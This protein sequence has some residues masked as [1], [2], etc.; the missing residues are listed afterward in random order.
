MSS[1]GVPSGLYYLST[2]LSCII[3]L[4][5]LVAGIITLARKRTLPGSLATAAFFLLGLHTLLGVI[6]SYAVLP[7]MHG[8]Y[9]TYSW[10]SYCVNTPIYL[11]GIITLV[12]LAFTNI[13]KKAEKAAPEAPPPDL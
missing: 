11:L 2:G 4:A 13:S 7:A 8:E 6:L 10:I 3:F 1:S 12:V 5:G 9:G